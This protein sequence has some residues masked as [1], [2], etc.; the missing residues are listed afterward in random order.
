MKPGAV[1]QVLNFLGTAT[2]LAKAL[3]RFGHESKSP[4]ALSAGL[5]RIAPSL[6]SGYRITVKFLPRTETERR[7]RKSAAKSDRRGRPPPGASGYGG[8]CRGA[9][10]ALVSD[11][12]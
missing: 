12:G 11:D 7:G 4:R 10:M 3:R 5:R 6:R 1:G 8:T 9:P 2:Q